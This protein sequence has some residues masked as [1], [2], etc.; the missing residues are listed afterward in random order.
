MRTPPSTSD[1][2]R[3]AGM[4]ERRLDYVFQEL[5]GASIFKTLTNARLDHAYKALQTGQVSV[6]EL[7][8]RLGYKHASSFSRAFYLRFGVYPS[9]VG[10]R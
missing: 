5:F 3:T 6:K 4:S 7:S 2:A 1:L 9:Q 10:S 8:F